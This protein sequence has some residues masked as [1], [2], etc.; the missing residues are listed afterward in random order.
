MNFLYYFYILIQSSISWS[1][2]LCATSFELTITYVIWHPPAGNISVYPLP[3]HQTGKRKHG[4]F[5]LHLVDAQ[6]VISP[7]N[8][9]KFVL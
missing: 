6:R 2:T 1:D 5:S 7:T 4:S 8:T 9:P 3:F